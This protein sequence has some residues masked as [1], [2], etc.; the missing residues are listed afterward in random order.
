MGVLNVCCSA[1]G[2]GIGEGIKKE[3]GCEGIRN[4]GLEPC[5]IGMMYGADEF[6][7]APAARCCKCAKDAGRVPRGKRGREGR[8]EEEEEDEEDDEDVDV[9]GD[10]GKPGKGKVGFEDSDIDIGGDASRGLE[11][12]TS[13]DVTSPIDDEALKV[14]QEAQTIPAAPPVVFEPEYEPLDFA[15]GNVLHREAFYPDWE[16][17][18]TEQADEADEVLVPIRLDLHVDNARV[19]DTFVWNLRE[20]SITPDQYAEMLCIDLDLPHRAERLIADSIRQQLG[21]HRDLVPPVPAATARPAPPGTL[22]G[23][24]PEC[25]V[26]IK[27]DLT[28][29]Q[30]LLHDQF[31]WDVNNPA[32]SPEPFARS[33]CQD[34]GL[35]RE[36]EASIAHSIRE[37]LA[38]HAQF[39]VP[40]LQGM[41]AR[42]HVVVTPERCVREDHE[43]PLW[44]PVVSNVTPA[45]RAGMVA[46][47]AAGFAYGTPQGPVRHSSR[48]REAASSQST[49]YSLRAGSTPNR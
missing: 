17:V 36:F 8:V 46:G 9:D 14:K 39:T 32:N 24:L 10:G 26:T 42:T 48:L 29:N 40:F 47:A 7:C 13:N 41:R 4:E 30:V 3:G 28:V 31:E 6:S 19:Q 18:V 2:D 23:N 16:K 11:D 12:E 37:Q 1:R 5:D 35:S 21:E 33:L 22:Y 45:Q 27:V 38:Y 34:L 15:Q 49:P 25:L 20:K 43:L 44:T